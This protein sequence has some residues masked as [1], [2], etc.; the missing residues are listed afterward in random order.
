MMREP[1]VGSYHDADGTA[2]ELVVRET[3]DG[4]WHVLDLD[5][6]EETA[7][8]VDA[9]AGGE[10][11][12]PQAEAIACDYLTTVG[13]LEPAAGPAAAE[14]IPEQ[15]GSDARSHRRPRPAPRQHRAREAALPRPAR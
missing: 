13:G 4:G 14:P 3:V 1:A 10:D 12:R 2:H 9:L 6:N 5:L 11:G 15:G 8:V 7:H